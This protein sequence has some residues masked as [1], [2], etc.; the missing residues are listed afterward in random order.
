VYAGVQATLV[1]RIDANTYYRSN[2][3]FLSNGHLKQ[4]L[5]NTR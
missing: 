3:L 1:L 4:T 5:P 2:R